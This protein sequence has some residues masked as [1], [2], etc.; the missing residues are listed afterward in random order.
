MDVRPEDTVPSWGQ[1]DELRGFVE[2]ARRQRGSQMAKRLHV[3]LEGVNRVIGEE[4]CCGRAA[5]QAGGDSRTCPVHGD[6][7][8]GDQEEEEE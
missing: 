3:R 7:W 5:E 8:E 1:Q 2:A 6:D 4:C